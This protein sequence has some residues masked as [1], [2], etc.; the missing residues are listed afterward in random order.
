[1]VILE[2]VDEQNGMH[3][4]GLSASSGK[5]NKPRNQGFAAHRTAG[6]SEIISSHTPMRDRDCSSNFG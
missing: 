6:Q 3:R 2:A 5:Q 1:M 4:P